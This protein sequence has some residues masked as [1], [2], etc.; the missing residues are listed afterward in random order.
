MNFIKLTIDTT[1]QDVELMTSRLLDL[2]ITGFELD[3]GG[4]PNITVYLEDNEQGRGTLSKVQN[5][6][7]EYKT[8]YVAEEDWA[9]NWKQYFKPFNVGKLT[10]LPTWETDNCTLSTI[11]CQLTIDPG[12]AFGTGQHASTYLCLEL[13]SD[14]VKAGDNVTDIGCGSG[15]LSAAAGLLGADRITAIDISENATRITKETLDT[16]NIKNYR[17]FCGDLTADRAL[18]KELG[19]DNDIIIANIT[20]DIIISMVGVFPKSNKLLL[21]GIIN[22]RLPEVTKALNNAGYII[23][24]TREK[25]DWVALVC[26]KN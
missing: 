4:F 26:I 23:I 3:S 15:I 16:N 6:G 25:E 10:I 20:A 5:L 17:I 13:L 14:H 2:G 11:N 24:E 8:G 21:S 22:T 19:D 18:Q 1:N 7:Y 12:S 9:N